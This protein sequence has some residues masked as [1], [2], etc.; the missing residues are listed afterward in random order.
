MYGWDYLAGKSSLGASG[1]K[2][3][4]A[5]LYVGKERENRFKGAYSWG[6]SN[7]FIDSNELILDIEIE[8]PHMINYLQLDGP[9]HSIIKTIKFSH[10]GQTL[11]EIPYYNE[12]V[13]LLNDIYYK[14]NM[15][16]NN[17]IA[18]NPLQEGTKDILIPPKERGNNILFNPPQL[19][20]SYVDNIFI[21]NG[22]IDFTSTNKRTFSI[23]IFSYI[24]GAGIKKS[25]LV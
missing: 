12:I 23:P 14:N 4:W 6:Y 21:K 24:F 25:K 18:P 10:D 9:T 1:A 8:N 16:A 11:E 20:F 15:F 2:P 5:Q 7:E 3:F 17:V 22:F 19:G 13:N